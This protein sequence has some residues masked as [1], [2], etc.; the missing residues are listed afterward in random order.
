[1]DQEFGRNAEQNLTFSATVDIACHSGKK[2]CEINA[3]PVVKLGALFH[4]F[5]RFVVEDNVNIKF[6][7]AY[8]VGEFN[9]SFA[10][11]YCMTVTDAKVDGIAFNDTTDQAKM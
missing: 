3:L 6:I 7:S 5:K 10:T 1:M 2:H 4:K 11:Q 9:G 8:T